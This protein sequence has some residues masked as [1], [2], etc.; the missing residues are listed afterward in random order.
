MS[1]FASPVTCA[2]DVAENAD[3][4]YT[5][6][7]TDPAATGN[8]LPSGDIYAGK[9]TDGRMV[10]HNKLTI[11]GF[12]MKRGYNIYGGMALGTLGDATWNQVVLN[13]IR[14]PNAN[15][16]VNVYGGKSAGGDATHNTIILAGTDAKDR[17]GSKVGYN[18]YLFGGSAAAGKDAVTGN[19][20]QVEGKMNG[21]RSIQNF[22]YLKFVL[23]DRVADGDMMLQADQGPGQVQSFDWNKILVEVPEDW[24][25]DSPLAKHVKLYT[26]VSLTLT[27]YSPS[28]LSG[29]Q[30][31]WEYGITTNT[32]TPTASTV[33][34]SEIYYDKTQF[35]NAVVR[36]TSDSTD[37]TATGHTLSLKTI[38]AGKS[39]LGNTAS[40]NKLTL[41]GYNLTGSG[42]DFRG[43]AALGATGNATGNEVILKNVKTG[44][45]NGVVFVYGGYSEY[46]EATGNTITLKGAESK[47]RPGSDV[48]YYLHLYGGKSAADKDDVTGNTL[49]VMGKMNGA[50]E[51]LNFEKLKFFLDDTIVNG[52]MMLQ[53]TD[54][55]VQDFD[56]D[57]VSVEA[58]ADWGN[59]FDGEKRV[60]LYN[61]V[62]ITLNHYGSSASNGVQGDWEYGITTNTKTPTASTVTASELYYDKNQ[63]RNVHVSYTSD[64][65]DTTAT[66]HVLPAVRRQYLGRD[67]IYAGLSTLGN[68]VT[69]NTLSLE[70]TM[71]P[72][73]RGYTFAGGY[74]E[75]AAGD[76]TGNEV[77]LKNTSGNNGSGNQVYGG[78]SLYGKATEN[79][80]TLAGNVS[81]NDLS[82]Y[83]GE[84]NVDAVSGNVLQIKGQ[85][86]RIKSADRFERLRFVLDPTLA[87]GSTMLSTYYALQ[88]F[89]WKNVSVTGFSDWANVLART[90]VGSPALC[91]YDGGT[92]ITSFAN[93]SPTFSGDAGDYE[94]GIQASGTL[95]GTTMKATKLTLGGNR[96]QNAGK[97][98]D[99][100]VAGTGPRNTYAGL[101]T[102]GNTTNHNELNLAGGSHA[103]ARAGYTDAQNGGSMYNTLNL[104]TGATITGAGYAGFTTGLH[105]LANPYASENPD[106]VDTTKNADAAYNTIH[107]QGG[108]LGANGAL[109]GGYIANPA[110]AGN[111]EG[112][113][114][115]VESGTF[116]NGA[117]LFA[118][119]T[120][121][122]GNALGNIV[123]ITGGTF[124]G[125][126][127][128][129]GGYATGTGNATG[130]IV[131]I[132]GG[133]SVN[134]SIYGA[135]AAKSASGNL[136]RIED[137]IVNGTIV[138]GSGAVT[139]RNTIALSG[140]T[141]NG[142]VSGGTAGSRGNTLAVYYNAKNPTSRIQDFDHVERL[143]FYLGEDVSSTTPALLQ[144]DASAK[145]ITNLHVGV[146]IQGQ[147]RALTGEDVIHLMKVA[148]G[149]KLTMNDTMPN[150][151]TG[152]QGISLLYKFSLMKQGGNELVAKVLKA[153]INAKTKSL[154]ETRA[155][156]ADFLNRGSDLLAGSGLDSMKAGARKKGEQDSYSLWAAMDK[157][158]FRAHTGSYVDTN[159]YNLAV[160]WAREFDRQE[161][162]FLLSPFVEYGKGSYD[163]YLDDGTHGSG[164]VNYLGVG[165]LGRFEQESGLWA[166]SA[167][168]IGSS[169]SDYGGSLAEGIHTR[170]DERASYF[171]TSLGLG[172][173]F[174]DKAGDRTDVYLRYFYTRQSA[175]EAT[176]STGETYEFGAT[177]SSRARLGLSYTHRDSDRSEIRAG[178]AYEFEFDG[179]ATASFQGYDTASPSLYG[180]S[181][182]VELAYR[183]APKDSRL[184]YDWHVADWQGKREG[185]SGGVQVNW[186]F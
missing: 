160:G 139:E 147:A 38:Y 100:T 179:K 174:A 161:G 22:E 146:G 79:I 53:N 162:K 81:R 137:A 3:V 27:N 119:Y 40:N 181:Y 136:V 6:D 4:K 132:T 92:R 67:L 50:R 94:F 25:N 72:V 124:D 126:N 21:A 88:D 166:E 71:V 48:G 120:K 178:V 150:D 104:K 74:G 127:E 2:S 49:Q 180:G 102:Y 117:K 151:I 69:N 125:G 186:A 93:Y 85:N 149:G 176:L 5:T 154:T 156:M 64:A 35:Q 169:W 116:A 143:H 185:L 80:V 58:P 37:D 105:I 164:H 32:K 182:L 54:G 60:K 141:V 138:G 171:S 158:L 73:S 12:D 9:S 170:Y 23:D 91:L 57:K 152:M 159:G 107:V 99:V 44:N 121:G 39:T 97:G 20:L 177:D 128:I 123:T 1:F 135:R 15:G 140:A 145:D 113:A 129:Y 77:I 31:D 122:T 115:H 87:N 103:Y 63:F 98:M 55:H 101:S 109:Y 106:V 14:T 95:S 183:F 153:G 168:R 68:T 111:A 30:G 26:G 134:A 17:P 83:G 175:A 165:L 86:N 110:N 167:I 131:N 62:S 108:T 142:V 43:G 82:V 75:G 11:I 47:G 18:L 45:A 76:V 16:H 172:R 28:A 29:T 19:T 34:A 148:D 184:S 173:T 114:I 61:G 33:T 8:T 155:G 96:F 10:T 59:G 7:T 56:W 90:G 41:E 65:S 144:L 51:I 78:I 52:D 36:Y 157:G 84:S 24:G 130:N 118:G 70:G 13:N 133:T 46:G 66:G 42:W 163:S 112:N 89:D